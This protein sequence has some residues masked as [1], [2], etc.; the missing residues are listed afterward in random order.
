[1]PT[2]PRTPDARTSPHHS[3]TLK[4]SSFQS[5]GMSVPAPRKATPEREFSVNANA[6]GHSDAMHS[7]A[8]EGF[9]RHLLLIPWNSVL[10]TTRATR[11][12]GGQGEGSAYI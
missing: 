4:H 9:V 5:P 11:E 2:P 1:M 6:N 7:Q 3:P 8:E 12:I 10:S